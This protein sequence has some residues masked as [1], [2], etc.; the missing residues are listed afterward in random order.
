MCYKICYFSLV[1]IIFFKSFIL[2]ISNELVAY[3]LEIE[4]FHKERIQLVKLLIFTFFYLKE[5]NYM[6][7]TRNKKLN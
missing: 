4:S 7:K 2:S 3:S 6:N 1:L 5:N